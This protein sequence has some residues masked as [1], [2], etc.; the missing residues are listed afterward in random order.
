MRLNRGL[1]GVTLKMTQRYANKNRR[2][3]CV[4]AYSMRA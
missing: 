1:N 4:N 2:R 3:V